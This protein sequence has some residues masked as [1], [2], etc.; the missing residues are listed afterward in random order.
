MCLILNTQYADNC[1][2]RVKSFQVQIQN[3][4]FANESARHEQ[5]NQHNDLIQWRLK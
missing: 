5:N 1:R 2:A 4:L 3:G